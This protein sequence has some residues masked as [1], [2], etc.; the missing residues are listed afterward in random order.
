MELRLT[1]WCRQV[2]SI[3]FEHTRMKT[4]LVTAKRTSNLNDP[5]VSQVLMRLHERAD[6][7]DAAVIPDVL[8][9][10]GERGASTDQEMADLLAG[11]FMPIHPNAGRLLHLLAMSRPPGRIVEFGTSHGLSTLYLAAAVGPEEPPVITTE[12]EV[13]KIDFARANFEDAGLADRI[14]LRIGD[15]F[16]TLADLSDGIALLFLDGWKGLYLPLLRSL[17]PHLASGAIVV[18]DDTLLLPDLC[19]EYVDYVRGPTNS[20]VSVGLPLDDGLEVSVFL[21]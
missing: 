15:A 4:Y 1:Q 13:T 14:D 3:D 11:A 2:F 7:H 16:E 17:E 10:A 12:M 5:K 21:G 6:A 19:A 8:A 20:Y 9:A 18:A